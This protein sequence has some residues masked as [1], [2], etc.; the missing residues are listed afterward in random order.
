MAAPKMKPEADEWL[1]GLV[2]EHEAFTVGDI[3]QAVNKAGFNVLMDAPAEGSATVAITS[4]KDGCLLK[5][6]HEDFIVAVREAYV[7][8]RLEVC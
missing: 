5:R 8:F 4:N 7:A 1:T 3:I 6:K 2:Q